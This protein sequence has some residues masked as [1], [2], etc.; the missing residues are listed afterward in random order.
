MLIPYNDVSIFVITSRFSELL[1]EQKEEAISYL[2]LNRCSHSELP[3]VLEGLRAVSHYLDR[4]V[5]ELILENNNLP[6]LPGKVFATLRVLRL[7]LRNNRLERVSSGWL[8]GLHDSLLELFVVESDLRSLPVDSLENLHGLEAVTLQSKVMK[9]LPRFSGLSKLRYLQINSPA[10]LELAPRNFRDLPNLEQLHVFGSPRLIRLEAGVFRDLPRLQIVNITDCGIHWVHPRSLIDLPELKEISL[11]G[12]SIVDANMIGRVCMDLPSLSVIRLDRNRMNRLGEGTFTDL[13]VL[14]R[15]YLSRNLITEVF[16]GAFQRMPALKVVDLNH[17]LIHRVHPEFFPRG[18]GNVLEEIWLINNDLSHVTE[19][20]SL[21]EALPRLKF[22]DVSHNQIEE[23]PF[24]ALRG[25]PTLER[26]HLDH[27]RVAFLQRET[28]TAMPALRELRLKNNSLSNLLEAPFWNLPALKGLDLSGN[29]FRHI[30][31]R[32]LANLPNLRRL[33]ISGNA[34]GL[35]EPDS[36]LGTPALEYIN[37]SGNAL[38]VI[39]PLTFHHL[40]N[41]YELDIGWNRMLEIVPGLPRNIEHLYMPM[42][43][44]VALPAVSSQDLDLP[45]LRS[46]DLSANGIERILPGSLADLPNLRKLNFGY[47][48]LRILEDGAFD[49]LSRLEQLDLRYNR[50][51]TLHGRSFRPLRSLMDLNLRGNRLEVL[52]PDIFQENIRL[53]RLDLSRN[54]L[55]Q[56]PHAT[57]SN[58]RD[59]RELYASHNTLTELPGSLHGLTALEVLDLSFNKLNILSPETLSSLSALLELKLVR[60]RIRELREG[61]FDGLPRLTLID[62]ENNDLRIIERN[63]IRALPELQAIRLGKNRLQMIPS[64]A[65]TELPLLQSAELQENRIQEVASNAFIN[66]PHLLF[67]NLSHN[68]LSSLDYVGSESLRSL[69]VLDLSNN[70]LSKVSSNSLASME[71]LVELRMDNNRICTIQGSP[72]D[73][74]PR[75]RVLTLRSNRMASVSETAFKRLRSNIAVLDI[76]GNKKFFLFLIDLNS[77]RTSDSS[78]AADESP[79][80]ANETYV[81]TKN[82]DEDSLEA[83]KKSHKNEGKLQVESASRIVWTTPRTVS[84]TTKEASFKETSTQ[85]L[86][87]TYWDSKEIEN[88]GSPN[89]A[90]NVKKESNDD[91]GS[92]VTERTAFHSTPLLEIQKNFSSASQVTHETEA[93]ALSAF[94]IP[95]G[96]VPPSVPNLRPL[97]K[98][99]ITKVPSPRVGL[100]VESEK[101]KSVAQAVQRYMENEETMLDKDGL[102]NENAEI[103]EDNPF[104]WYFQHYNDTNLEPFVGIAYSGVFIHSILLPVIINHLHPSTKYLTNYM[105]YLIHLLIVLGATE[106][107]PLRMS[108]KDSST[109]NPNFPDSDYFYEYADYQD[110]KNDKLNT[111]IAPT[112]SQQFASTVPTNTTKVVE[113]TER[114]PFPLNNTVPIKKTTSV[115]P[116]PSSSGFTFFGVPLPNLNFNLWGNSGRKS[117]RKNSDRP[118]RSRYRIF[119]PTEPEVHRGGFVPLPRGQGGFI[120][121]VDPRLIYEKQ[122]ISRVRDSNDTQEERKRWKSGN[123]TVIKIE[124][125]HPRTNKPKIGSKEREE[126]SIMMTKGTDSRLRVTGIKKSSIDLN[127]TRT[128]D[129]STAADESPEKANETYVSTKNDDEDSLEANKKSHKNEGKLQVESASRIVWTTPRTVSETTKE[130]SFKETST[131]ILKHTYWDSKEIENQGSP[132]TATNVKK[133]SND[134]SGSTV[135]ERTAFHSTPLLEIQKNFSSASQVTH[136]TEASALSAFLIPG[137]QVPPSVP[138]LRPLG[139]PTITKVPSP[140]VG[141]SV[142]SE[143]QKSVAQAVQRYME[144]EET[145]LDK[146]GLSN[147]NAEIVEDNPFNWYFQ[148]YNDTN[149]EPFVGIAYSGGEKISAA[150][151]TLFSQMCLILYILI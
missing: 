32:L 11:I 7:M 83:N 27:N 113:S 29:Y 145:M 26:L 65:F 103:V 19:L 40:N 21:M 30:E 118:G 66:V 106:M 137:G 80:K 90:T 143:K 124:K 20:R 108:L 102:S 149:L 89:T 126:L 123:G 13:P 85:I 15:L 101:Q 34:V 109:R 75:L 128:S 37:I 88:Q 119:P 61:A 10:L 16:A 127:S 140:R 74:M 131:Q 105:K 1:E 115:P 93:S 136:E 79:E 3:K 71:W 62:L 87:H 116:S 5:D 72:F 59:L 110:S 129:S 144:N 28:F 36:F 135:T 57:F 107:V 24:G 92:T 122:E 68:H 142:E 121:I 125:T 151:W 76:D 94:L 134:D 25:H 146:D 54:N 84:E 112:Q 41:L 99:T 120:P 73:E 4:P 58:S 42:N 31:P 18:P 130:A 14:S 51:V 64:G 35:I 67:L 17:N 2:F 43:R 50:L 114:P 81:S 44:I 139:K 82:D 52:R 86:K 117:E 45:V 8:E 49:N 97:G 46:L 150:R 47:N 12:N 100:S 69:E 23:I 77:T 53:Q 91:S 22:L 48:S 38:S 55:A 95:G 63:A 138:N 98:P 33:D 141:L 111:T 78:T 39:H 133:E 56:I 147:E 60:N 148:H 9:K 132:N 104:N 6:S 70:R 96:Q